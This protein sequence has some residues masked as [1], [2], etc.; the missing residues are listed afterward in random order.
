MNRAFFHV[1][2]IPN[3]QCITDGKEFLHS[4]RTADWC[5]VQNIIDSPKPLAMTGLCAIVNPVASQYGALQAK[6]QTVIRFPPTYARRSNSAI[7][8]KVSHEIRTTGSQLSV[9]L[10]AQL[11]E[12][13]RSARAESDHVRTGYHTPFQSSFGFSS[14]R[15]QK[16]NGN[17][18]QQSN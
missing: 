18:A 11:L 12:N 5:S 15:D 13:L 8:I 17:R 10:V 7:A 1:S 2:I 16:S 9:S 6:R 3:F 4:F 14:S